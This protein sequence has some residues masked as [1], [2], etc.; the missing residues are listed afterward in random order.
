MQSVTTTNKLTSALEVS[1]SQKVESILVAV[2]ILSAHLPLIDYCS[3]PWQTE[4]WVRGT[5][6]KPDRVIFTTV[7]QKSKYK[8]TLLAIGLNTLL[9]TRL[10]VGLGLIYT[11]ALF[12]P[13]IN[14]I[15]VKEYIKT[16]RS[17][18]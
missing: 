9:Q 5:H 4:C 8:V 18:T 10:Y 3:P 6:I 17:K 2:F 15:L 1:K 14:V 16:C 13:C 7:F 12:S 11:Q